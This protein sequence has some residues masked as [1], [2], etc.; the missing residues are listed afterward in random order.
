MT[1]TFLCILI[2]LVASTS[3]AAPHWRGLTEEVFK[4]GPVKITENPGPSAEIIQ[5]MLKRADMSVEFYRWPRARALKIA[6]SKEHH[7]LFAIPRT[8][9]HEENYKWVGPVTKENFLVVT[10]ADK[11]FEKV[12]EISDLRRFRVGTL[13]GSAEAYVLESHGCK[14]EL[15]AEDAQNLQKL[16]TGRI[17]FYMATPS[18]IKFLEKEGFK[19]KVILNIEN[20]NLYAAFHRKTPEHFISRFNNILE[21]MKKDGTTEKIKAKYLVAEEEI[22]K[23]TL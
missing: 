6:E 7:F 18:H 14:P 11:H 3:K 13:Y 9:E 16:K 23:P 22:T 21:R 4:T 10:L 1:K 5:E 20:L 17:D 15:V 12:K 8:P 2:V 19:F